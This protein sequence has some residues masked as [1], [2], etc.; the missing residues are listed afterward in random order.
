MTQSSGEFHE[1]W[2][3][4]L[5]ISQPDLKCLLDNKIADRPLVVFTALVHPTRQ[6]HCRTRS[7]ARFGKEFREGFRV[8]LIFPMFFTESL[9]GLTQ[10]TKVQRS[11]RCT[12]KIHSKFYSH[13]SSPCSTGVLD[14]L[15]CII[16]SEYF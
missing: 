6:H 14:V 16:F 11:G 10:R 7:D 13:F 1:K 2:L 12:A 3:A 5:G 9:L 8:G 4:R 15:S